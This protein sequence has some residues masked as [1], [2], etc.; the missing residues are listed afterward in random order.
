MAAFLSVVIKLHRESLTQMNVT[1]LLPPKSVLF[2]SARGSL[3]G[4]PD[5]YVNLD[6]TLNWFSVSA[7]GFHT[8]GIRRYFNSSKHTLPVD[9]STFD[10]MSPDDAPGQLRFVGFRRK[11]SHPDVTKM[12]GNV[13]LRSDSSAAA[14]I[15]RS[16][17]VKEMY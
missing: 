12:L 15:R 6:S 8:C 9:W 5:L 17:E 14:T 10:H 13:R 16:I 4:Y 7:G 2:S 1:T 3:P 11:R